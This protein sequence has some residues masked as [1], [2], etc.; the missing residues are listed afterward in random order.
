MNEDLI[1]DIFFETSALSQTRR[2]KRHDGRFITSKSSS[3][4]IEMLLRK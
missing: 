4:S 3:N 1:D 2:R